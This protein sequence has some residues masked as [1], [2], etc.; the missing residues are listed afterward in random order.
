MM[1]EGE[2]E[3]TREEI[4]GIEEGCDKIEEVLEKVVQSGD[5]RKDMEEKLQTGDE[6]NMQDIVHE[7]KPTDPQTETEGGKWF[8][9]EKLLKLWNGDAV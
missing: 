5:L 2:I 7:V 6:V 4:K 8:E 9:N 1:M 3:R